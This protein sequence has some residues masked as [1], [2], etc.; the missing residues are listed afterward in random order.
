[1][2]KQHAARWMMVMK[3]HAAATRIKSSV[4]RV[5]AMS[6]ESARA[7]SC[8]S[9]VDGVQHVVGDAAQLEEEE[10]MLLRMIAEQ[11]AGLGFG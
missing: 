7:W 2:C 9:L 3:S 1:M 5:C 4:A 11:D 8:Q 10:Q 6:S